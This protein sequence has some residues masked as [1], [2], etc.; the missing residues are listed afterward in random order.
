MRIFDVTWIAE[1]VGV[2]TEVDFGVFS[3]WPPAKDFSETDRAYLNSLPSISFSSIHLFNQIKEK[4][5]LL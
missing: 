4:E 1:G 5:I 3:L 2:G